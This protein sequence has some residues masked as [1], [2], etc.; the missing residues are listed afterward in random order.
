M[1]IASLALAVVLV[2]WCMG[3]RD[4]AAQT[5]RPA[6]RPSAAAQDTSAAVPAGAGSTTRPASQSPEEMLN[7]LLKPTG[8]GR[9]AAPT[10]NPSGAIDVTSGAGAVAPGAPVVAVMREGTDI[11]NRVGRLTRSADGQLWEFTFDSDGRTMLDPPLIIL[12]N[13][14]L[15]LME[16]S[17]SGAS[18]DQRFRVTGEVTEYRGRNYILLRKATVVSDAVKQF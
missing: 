7:Q 5:T 12:P 18:R 13:L 15:M 4:A 2:G 8:D 17:V 3:S 6:A 10:T 14:T 11:V 1:R 16:S 9:P